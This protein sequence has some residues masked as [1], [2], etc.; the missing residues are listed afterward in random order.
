MNSIKNEKA[1]L[2]IKEM[3]PRIGSGSVDALTALY[4]LYDERMYLWLAGL[5]DG[6]I[7]GFYFSNSARDNSQFLPDLESTMQ[8][9]MHLDLSGLL[10][11]Y[12]NSYVKAFADYPKVKDAMISFAKRLQ[13]P[14][15]GYFYHPQWKDITVNSAR[16]GRDLGWATMLLKAFGEAPLYNA[17]DGT[18]GSLGS[19]KNAKITE[20]KGEDVA[21]PEHLLSLRAFSEYVESLDIAHRSYDVGNTLASQHGQIRRAGQEY[22]DYLIKY[23]ES[24]QKKETGIW[25]EEIN[26]YSLNGLMKIGGIYNYF[27]APMPNIDVSLKTVMS[28]TSLPNFD[29]FSELDA[30]VCSVYNPWVI[31][32]YLLRS[33][34]ATEGEEKVASLRADIIKNSAKML[35]ATYEKTKLFKESDGGF[36][37]RIMGSSGTSQRAPVAIPGTFESD[38]NA[39]TIMATDITFNIFFALGEERV[40]MFSGDQGKVF[41]NML[42]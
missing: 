8:V 27:G 1:F 24:K 5:W 20:E 35:S 40:R 22:V 23:L 34:A 9:L 36:R 31:M 16:L 10:E 14:D 32:R 42:K 12:D 41:L 37:Y 7:G 4:E 21:L 3:A 11:D 29:G 38:V 30:H 33:A 19:P 18:L 6:E 15:D 28:L 2:K 25:E 13:S 39:S 26:Y 17:P